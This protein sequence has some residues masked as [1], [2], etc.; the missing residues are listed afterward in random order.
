[1]ANLDITFDDREFQ[2][3]L[4]YIRDQLEKE[5]MKIVINGA[6]EIEN[7]AKSTAPKRYGFLRASIGHVTPDLVTGSPKN[8]PSIVGVWRQEDEPNIKSIEVG[9][10]M[11]YAWAMENYMGQSSISDKSRKIVQTREGRSPYLAPAFAVV[12]PKVEKELMILIRR[13][14]RSKG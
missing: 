11:K 13:V 12:S 4:T 14:L 5:V 8:P 9:S 6:Q 3:H 2:K 1:M 7:I 10:G